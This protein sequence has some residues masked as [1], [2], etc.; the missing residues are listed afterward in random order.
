ML[1]AMASEEDLQRSYYAGRAPSYEAAHVQEGDEHYF[2]L[3]VLTGAL[4]LL[5]ATSVLEVGAGTGRGLRHLA[6]HAPQLKLHGIE[7]VAELRE[8]A[9]G[10]GVP[11]ETISEGDAREL[12][13]PDGAFDVVCA[14]GV[15]HHV[16]DHAQVVREMLRVA[17]K[18]IFISDSNNFGQGGPLVRAFKQLLDVTRLWKLADFIKTRGKGY[19]ITEG[20]GLAY[21]Y[22]L[23]SDY[24]LI[25]QRCRRVHLINTV[26]AGIHPY[27]SASHVAL[28]GVK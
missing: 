4:D 3:A 21:S 5:G 28:L 19:S 14:F 18:A 22:S 9:Y 8:V 12:A 2:A 11:R 24:P 15:L 23:F 7:P 20:D 25:R 27:R 26:D 13:F 10:S 6:Q 1:L 17:R 16:R